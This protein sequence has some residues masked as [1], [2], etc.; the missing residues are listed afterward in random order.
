MLF[1]RYFL[2]W[3]KMKEQRLN[4]VRLRGLL[5]Q[6]QGEFDLDARQ[7]HCRKIFIRY[8]KNGKKEK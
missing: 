7:N 6:K 4:N 3:Q 1:Y 2:L 8:I 5:L